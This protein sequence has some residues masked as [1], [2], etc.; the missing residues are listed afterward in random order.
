MADPLHFGTFGGMLTRAI[1]FVFGV[2]LT[3]LSISGIYIYGARIKKVLGKA[4][5]AVVRKR[6]LILAWSGMSHWRWLMLLPISIC[7]YLV[8]TIN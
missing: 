1:W 8:L 4:P 3:G 6:P 2:I 7:L 5:T